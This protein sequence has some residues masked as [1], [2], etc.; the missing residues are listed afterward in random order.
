M[1]K[2]ALTVVRLVEP[3]MLAVISDMHMAKEAV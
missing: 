3:A 2:M 1:K